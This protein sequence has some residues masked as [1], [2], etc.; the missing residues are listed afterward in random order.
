MDEKTAVHETTIP[1]EQA[2]HAS[3]REGVGGGDLQ[4]LKL[5]DAGDLKL[6]KDG[7]TVLIPQP[8]DDPN[9]SRPA[10]FVAWL[11]S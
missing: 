4:V 2:Q 7:V 10:G 6:A 1:A 9:V 3:Y 8:S 11:L 5:A